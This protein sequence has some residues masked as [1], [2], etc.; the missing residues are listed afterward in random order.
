M[1]YAKFTH[2]PAGQ[3]RQLAVLSK[4]ELAIGE[5][6]T[7]DAEAFQ[8]LNNLKYLYLQQ[9]KLKELSET[10]FNPLAED[11]FDMFLNGNEISELPANLFQ[12]QKTIGVSFHKVLIGLG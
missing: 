2:I 11:V 4:L 1:N 8:G 9:N 12:E 5:I 3:F 6:E 7:L 10:L